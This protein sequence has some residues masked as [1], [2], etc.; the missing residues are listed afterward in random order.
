MCRDDSEFNSIGVE[1]TSPRALA[2]GPNPSGSP[3]STGTVG[4]PLMFSTSV[5]GQVHQ[6]A[7]ASFTPASNVDT[8]NANSSPPSLNYNSNSDMLSELFPTSSWNLD[9]DGSSTT[10]QTPRPPSTSAVSS[11]Y[12]S[13]FNPEFSCPQ[14]D[15][16][17]SKEGVVDGGNGG[18]SGRLR[19]L[20]SQPSQPTSSSGDNGDSGIDEEAR[21]KDRILIGLLNQE[22]KDE[23]SRMSPA[24]PTREQPKTNNNNMLLKV[25]F[26]TFDI[27]LI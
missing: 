26:S 5:N 1:G 21:S 9:G 12:N 14:D 8:L 13:N 6:R 24:A 11:P 25:N 17:D 23:R 22:D 15:S 18:E 27:F 2:I 7:S 10:P 3:A 16:K 19:N 4:G 20:L